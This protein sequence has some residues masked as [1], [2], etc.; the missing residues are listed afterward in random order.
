MASGTMK[1]FNIKYKDVRF[2]SV[3][4]GSGGYV[5]ID[6]YIPSDMNNFLF[7]MVKDCASATSG[8]LAV[9]VTC[10]GRYLF[11]AG[12]HTFTNLD[13]RYYYTD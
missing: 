13:I 10:D 2:P 12:G 6:S 1:V 9:N 5:K 8:D 3:S 4:T 7:A 11:S